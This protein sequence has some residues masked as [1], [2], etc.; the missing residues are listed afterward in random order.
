MNPSAPSPRN[1][2]HLEQCNHD[3]EQQHE[4]AGEGDG[5]RQDIEASAEALPGESGECPGGADH[6]PH[7]PVEAQL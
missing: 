4:P 3:G 1:D 2:P 6:M 7:V 5:D